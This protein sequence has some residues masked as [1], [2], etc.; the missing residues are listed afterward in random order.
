MRYFMRLLFEKPDGE[1]GEV[2]TGLREALDS[3]NPDL[4]VEPVGNADEG[5]P[6]SVAPESEA[7]LEAPG[8]EGEPEGEAEAEPEGEADDEGADDEEEEEEAATPEADEDEEEGEP[9]GESEAVE[10][11]LA[12]DFI[13]EV[14]DQETADRLREM[15]DGYETLRA[16]SEDLIKQSRQNQLDQDSLQLLE[17]EIRADPAGYVTRKM[18]AELRA[19]VARDLLLDDGVYQA[20]RE[21][22]DE[23]ELGGVNRELAK[24]RRLR[25]KAEMRNTIE[26]RREAMTTGRR[27]AFELHDRVKEMGGALSSEKAK[28]VWERAAMARLSEYVQ[29]HKSRGKH[30][31]T[32]DPK[33]LDRILADEIEAFGIGADPADNGDGSASPAAR[34]EARA[35]ETGERFRAKTKRRKQVAATAPAGAG[36]GPSRRDFSGMSL[37][38][39]LD[40]LRGK[41]S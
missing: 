1:A 5:E 38:Q 16:Q 12:D 32:I 3:M 8:E 26:E 21:Q 41:G 36:A 40:S 15:H 33:D 2:K 27:N 13:L 35:R 6:D 34:A 23:W 20:V 22:I 28:A 24:E 30:I 4:A 17:D 14:E 7:E 10:V 29:S 18:A 9:E 37:D 11:A 31:E 25:E 39:A 19:E